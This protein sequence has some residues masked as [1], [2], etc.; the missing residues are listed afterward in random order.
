MACCCTPLV[1]ET[2]KDDIPAD[3][4]MESYQ[5]LLRD[6]YP[7]DRVVLGVFPAAMRYA[8]PREA[9]FHAIARKNYGCTHFIVGRDHAGV[10]NYY[11]TYDAQLIFDEFKPEELGITPLFFEHSFYC[12]KCE[13]IVTAKTC[14]HDKSNYVFLSGT[15]VREKLSNGELLPKEFTRPEVSQILVDGMRRKRETEAVEEARASGKGRKVMVI[16][17]DC[18]D[19]KLVFDQWKNDLPNLNRLMSKGMYGDLCS[20]TP[21]ITVPAWSSMLTSKDP[22]Q[23][24]FYGFRNRADYSYDRMSNA[25]S[26]AVTEDTVWDILSREGKQ[27]I[28]LGIPQT[29]PPKPVNGYVITDFLTPSIN[30]QYT[31][32]AD[33]KEEIAQWV[34]EYMLD[35]PNFRTED[36]SRLLKDIYEMTRRRFEV[37]GHLVTEKPWDFFMMVEMGIDRIHHGFWKYMDQTHPKYEA[38]NKYENAIRDYYIYVDEL[39]GDLLRKVDDDTVVMVVSDHGAMK[40]DGGIC[41][42][43]W[44]IQQGYLTLKEYPDR[45]VPLEKVEVDWSRTKAW[46]SGGYYARLFL[47]VEGREPQGVIPQEDYEATRQEIIAALEGICDPDGNNI[48]TIAL[49]PQDAYR[50][51]KNIPP[52]LIVYFGGLRWRSVGSVGSK[53]VYTFENDTGPDDANHAQHGIGIMYDPKESP[54]PANRS[55]MAVD[56]HC[57]QHS[58]CDGHWRAGGYAGQGDHYQGRIGHPWNTKVSR[59]GSRAFPA[60][61]RPTLAREV[62]KDLR[63]RG[64]KVEILDGDIVRQNLSK[65][66]GFSKEDRDINIRRIGFVW[67]SLEP[68][69]RRRDWRRHLTLSRHSR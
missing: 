68:Q 32:P 45:Q 31:Y 23:L 11:G 19:P 66:L 53:Q 26:R 57:P 52:D 47:N 1:G 49:K 40:M 69:Q 4:R 22:G 3:V 55:E 28:L 20:S 51:I 63:N 59:Y 50:E 8:G 38:G 12:T 54:G 15:Q 30:S 21:P 16:G 56:G 62:E 58:D 42:N 46:G 2:K 18:A 24:G 67:Q 17:L 37:A 61:A 25:N 9:I 35:V 5:V 6:Y 44:L 48:G 36:K 34:G 13:A 7:P 33:L 10:G 65:G 29:Y 60:P 27:C 43:E 64:M 14:P 39:I 41:I